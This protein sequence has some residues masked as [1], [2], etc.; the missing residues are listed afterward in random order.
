MSPSD[1]AARSDA[2]EDWAFPFEAELHA[3]APGVH[4]AQNAWLSQIDSLRAPDRKTHELIRTACAVGARNLEGVKLH[5]R[6]AAE[7]GA[8]WEDVAGALILT[9]PSFGLVGAVEALPVARRAWEKGRAT[10]EDGAPA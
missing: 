4:E 3:V 9:E 2:G 10:L 1:D 5:A 6:L 7:V 8:T